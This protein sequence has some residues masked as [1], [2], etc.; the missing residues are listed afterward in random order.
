L[1][2]YAINK[3]GLALEVVPRTLAENAGLDA[4]NIVA[5]L[6]AAHKAGKTNAGINVVDA[7]VR[8]RS[9]GLG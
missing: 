8:C 5:E 3:Y 4:A 2:Q 7:R 1:D 6:Y 9:L